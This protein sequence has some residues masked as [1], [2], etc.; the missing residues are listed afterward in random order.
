[1][2][3]DA[4]LAGAKTDHE[5]LSLL[6]QAVGSGLTLPADALVAG[7]P[8]QV[9]TVVYDGHPR[10]G[11]VAICRRGEESHEV[12]LADVQFGP[13]AD[14]SRVSA[15]YR[16]W[17]G[18]EP[19]VIDA[20]A[21]AQARRHKAEAGELEPGKPL[22]LVVLARKSNALRCR[23]LGTARELTLRVPVRDEPP[24][25]IVT[26]LPAKVWTHARHPYASGKVLGCRLDVAALGLVPLALRPEGDWDP[27]EEYWGEEGRPIPE[28]ERSIK[29]RGSRP[30]FEM[31]QVLPG[32]DSEDPDSDPIFEAVELKE[33]G[34]RGEAEA[35]LMSL[36]AKDLRCLDAHAH[37]GNWEFDLRPKQAL[38]HYSVGV[39]IG[40]LALGPAFEGVL[41]WGLV[42]NRPYLRCLH[43]L[44]I[45]AWRLGDL[46]GAD[47]V[48]RRLLWLNPGDNQGARINL[49]EVEAGRSWA[50]CEGSRG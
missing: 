21:I 24:G 44:G 3:L 17:L 50:E 2:E 27:E 48:F 1:M 39:G 43:G 33:G 6:L 14:G 49:T 4:V 46:Q 36:L 11:L 25:E 7:E 26:V 20:H 10:R 8:V 23:M 9:V 12:G 29:D 47:K 34:G 18:L 37:L 16:S 19:L 35:L 31:E 41:P 42:D 38:R 28:W 15:L 30:A 22:D 40:D 13:G 5:Q 45:S 32:Q